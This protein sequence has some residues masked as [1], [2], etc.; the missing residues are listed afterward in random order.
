MHRGSPL[1]VALPAL[2]GIVAAGCGADPVSYSDGEIADGLALRPE[3]NTYLVATEDEPEGDAFC[4]VSDLLNDA[5]E[6]DKAGKRAEGLAISSREG[7]A[8]VV[9]EP[10]FGCE[11]EVRRNLNRLDPAPKE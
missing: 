3:R 4:I 2:A 11:D 7:T 6:V 8:G 5:D 10:P 9:T 1:L